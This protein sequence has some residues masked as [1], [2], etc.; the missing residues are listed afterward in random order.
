MIGARSLF[1]KHCGIFL[2]VEKSNH[3]CYHGMDCSSLPLAAGGHGKAKVVGWILIQLG[4]KIF[5][6]FCHDYGPLECGD[7]SPHSKVGALDDAVVMG[8]SRR[9]SLLACRKGK[10]GRSRGVNHPRLSLAAGG[11]DRGRGRYHSIAA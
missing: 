10:Q 1:L 7:L 2:P 8:Q 5:K 3:A 11:R 6:R 4:F 9:L